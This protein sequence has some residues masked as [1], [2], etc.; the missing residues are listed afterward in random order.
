MQKAVT[1]HFKDT[2]MSTGPQKPKLIYFQNKYETAL[3]EFLLNHKQEHVRCLSFFFDVVVINDDCDYQQVCDLHQPDVALFESGVN[4]FTCRRPRI[5]NVKS[6]RTIPKLALLNADAWCETRTGSFA[7]MELWGV[8]AVFSIAATAPEHM[9][10]IAD[11]L[12]VWPNSIDPKIYRDYQQE[13][14][15]PVLLSGATAALY[16]WRRR[17][18][19]LI[20]QH[21][22]TLSCP[23]RGY[24]SRTSPGQVFAGEPYARLLNAAKISPACG[25]VGGEVVRK[26]FEIP[27]CNTCLIT[28][29]TT[30]IKQAGF[31]DMKNCV[32]GDSHDLLDKLE[33]LFSNEEQLQRI[34]A[35]GYK[36]VHA[37]HTMKQRDQILQ[38]Y[39]LNKKLPAHHKI[40]QPDP[41]RPLQVVPAGLQESLPPAISLGK[42]LQAMREGDLHLRAGDI[43]A[44]RARYKLC[45]SY[46]HR[47]PEARFKI[48]LCELYA[49]KASL[50]NAQIFELIQYCLDEYGA[51]A[52]D[53]VEWAYYILSLMCTGDVRGASKYAEEFPM[54]RHPELDRMRRVFCALNRAGDCDKWSDFSTRHP[55]I[56]QCPQQTDT[57]WLQ[58]LYKTLRKCGQETLAEKITVA[59]TRMQQSAI[60]RNQPGS[61]PPKTRTNSASA[62]AESSKD[63][64][65]R[66]GAL[67]RKLLQYKVERKMTQLR[68]HLK[69]HRLLSARH[70]HAASPSAP[71]HI[72]LLTSIREITRD[73][74]VRTVLACGDI[75]LDKACAAVNEG[76][77]GMPSAPLIFCL[78]APALNGDLAAI[79]QEKMIP[80]FKAN[81]A[82]ENFDLIFVAW[83]EGASAT[84][85]TDQF[86][87]ELQLARCLAF[88]NPEVPSARRIIEGLVANSDYVLSDCDAIEE[89]YAI[90]MKKTSPQQVPM[91]VAASEPGNHLS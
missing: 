64:I 83:S 40:I 62:L 86:V 14:L 1:Q 63:P 70:R 68:K 12:F 27:A 82:I 20:S 35:D 71:G 32:L 58:S 8:D 22:P 78:K 18:Y 42:H 4:L 50:A 48:A 13:K 33:L 10:E 76:A 36:L 79:E 65:G 17:V 67:S 26:H 5:A 73:M 87:A 21:Y 44:A 84:R 85:F 47:F 34:T 53:P 57:E 38:W 39:L 23:H 49:G 30:H 2:R 59:M 25:T 90:L 41:F 24:L 28:E 31:V 72:A 6:G 80:Q 46:M 7:D 52:P 37:S 51:S 75:L 74:K 61:T 43:E 69:G 9:P 55:S 15:I 54:L 29:E 11:K 19:R 56:H 77:I 16:P 81:N 89:S 45:L 60:I 66:S 91:C 3:P 88:A